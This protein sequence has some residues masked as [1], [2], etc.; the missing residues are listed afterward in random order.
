MDSTNYWTLERRA[1]RGRKKISGS[2]G[3][4]YEN[5]SNKVEFLE[6]VFDRDALKKEMEKATF[7]LYPSEAKDGETFGLA[8]L[9]AMSCVDVY[10]LFPIY[11]VL[12]ISFLLKRKGFCLKQ[13]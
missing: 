3:K 8:V 6:P 4:D 1:G 13:G 7:F 10:L 11:H 9:E 12:R 2:F 5:D